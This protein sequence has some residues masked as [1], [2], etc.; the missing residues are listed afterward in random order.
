MKDPCEIAHDTGNNTLEKA[1]TPLTSKVLVSHPAP[2]LA[3]CPRQVIRG[4]SLYTP[5]TNTPKQVAICDWLNITFKFDGSPEA[6]DKFVTGWHEYVGLIFGGLTDQH[7]GLHGYTHSFNFDDGGVKFAFGGQNGTA[8]ISIP[9]E[10][11]AHIKDWNAVRYFFET[12]LEGR[13]TRWDG[14]VDDFEGSH[15]VDLA[16]ECYV[17]GLFGTGG[18]KPKMKQVG[19]WVEPDGTGRT[20]YIGDRKNGKMLRV[21]EKGKQL[22]DT[23]SP[24]VRWELQL[25]NR[26]RTIPFEVLTNPKP[27]IAGAYKYLDW[28]C[29]EAS[30][31]RTT[32]KTGDIA[33]K[34]LTEC[35]RT[36]YG[37]HINVMMEVEGS[38]EAVV[39]KIIRSGVPRRL[40]LH[41][42]DHSKIVCDQ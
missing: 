8:F 28:V 30:R 10:G 13:V 40:N 27:Y 37:P 14:A 41:G 11:C 39:K 17:A 15:S 21:Y 29:D 1:A 6:V 31:I 5:H 18:N 9:G 7:K 20:L 3:D 16:L 42:L 36:A 4:E 19:N 34:K 2:E 23:I 24:W 35:L 12:V 33:Y 26:D 25:N 38:F 22:G 32:Q